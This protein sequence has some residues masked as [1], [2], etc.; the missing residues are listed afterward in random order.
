MLEYSATTGSVDGVRYQLI[1]YHRTLDLKY[2]DCPQATQQGSLVYG[3]Q[4]EKRDLLE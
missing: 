2:P 4:T 3:I 1:E